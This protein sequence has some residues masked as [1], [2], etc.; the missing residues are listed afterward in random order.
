MDIVNIIDKMETLVATSPSVPLK[1]A[2]M[3]DPNKFM[4]LVDQL[5]LAVPQDVRSAQELILKKDNLLHQAQSDANRTRVE[6]EQEFKAKLDQ[7]E[8]IAAAKDKADELMEDAQKRANRLVEQAEVES[9]TKRAEADA[10]CL[11]TLRSLE[12]ELAGILVSIKKGVEVLTPP[13]AAVT[14]A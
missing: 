14:P 5:R 13:E 6:A 7:N 10:Y 8:I 11:Q 4:E 9:H 12:K 2:K 3:V 1:G